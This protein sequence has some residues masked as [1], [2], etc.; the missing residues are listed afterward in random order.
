MSNFPQTLQVAAG[1]AGPEGP[2]FRGPLCSLTPTR[3]RTRPLSRPELPPHPH[4]GAPVSDPVTRTAAAQDRMGGHPPF[5]HRGRWAGASPPPPVFPLLQTPPWSPAHSGL[6]NG[7]MGRL[8]SPGLPMWILLCP[9]WWALGLAVCLHL[10]FLTWLGTP[11]GF[12][13][14]TSRCASALGWELRGVGSL[15]RM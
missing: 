14:S 8:G 6:L 15:C 7:P 13:L 5:D 3:H 9:P 2:G 10:V 1:A 11:W 12:G 4:S